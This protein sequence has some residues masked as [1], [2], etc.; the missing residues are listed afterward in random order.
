VGVFCVGVSV[1]IGAAEGELTFVRA[2]SQGAA[3]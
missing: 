1:G 3:A 2:R